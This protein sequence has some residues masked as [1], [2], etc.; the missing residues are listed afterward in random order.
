MQEGIEHTGE[1]EYDLYRKIKDRYPYRMLLSPAHVK[2]LISDSILI[3]KSGYEAAVENLI[4][5]LGEAYPPS[6]LDFDS[7][8]AIYPMHP[9]TLEL[10][11]EV[12][13]RFSQAR[14]IVDF[15][16][17]RLHGE[18]ARDVPG[19]LDRPFGELLT[20]R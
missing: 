20:A 19:F 2:A 3:K 10:L 16:V 1:L 4:R 11:E 17:T 13:D 5:E 14:G 12:R 6:A 7:L 18:P 8:R 9:N 15:T